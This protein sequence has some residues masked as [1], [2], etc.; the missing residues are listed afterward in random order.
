M[1]HPTQGNRTQ[2]RQFRLG[3]ETLAQLDAISAHYALD[4]RAD[5]IRYAAREA[6]SRL[7]L[8]PKKNPTNSENDG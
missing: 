5:A 1:P 7:R 3:E 2:A 6:V 4:S 8:R